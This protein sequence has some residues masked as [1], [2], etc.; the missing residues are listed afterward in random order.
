MQDLVWGA[1]YSPP[2]QPTGPEL[3]AHEWFREVT[4]AKAPS[5]E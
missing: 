3:P 1:L 2:S 5:A 4:S